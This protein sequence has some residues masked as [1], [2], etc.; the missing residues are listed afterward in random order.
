MTPDLFYNRIMV[1]AVLTHDLER[2]RRII[3]EHLHGYRTRVY[4]FGSQATGEAG[5]HSDIDV[6]VLPLEP[7]PN[8][9]LFNIREELEKSDIVRHVDVIDL[10]ETDDS[11]RQRVEKEGIVWKE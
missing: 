1:T 11:F 2:T 6:A 4:L 8:L 10:S 5:L 9:A 7:L 3:L